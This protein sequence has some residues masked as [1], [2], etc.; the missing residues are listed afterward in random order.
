MFAVQDDIAEL[1]DLKD[2]AI[3]ATAKG[4]GG[5]YEGYLTDDALALTPMGK[6][7]KPAIVKAMTGGSRFKSLGVDD[8]DARL[9]GP[10]TGL[11][12]YRARFATP[13]GG[14]VTMLTSTVYCRRDGEWHGA[15][16]QQTP[17]R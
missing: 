2:A 17:Q 16:Y 11:V 13:E 15:F 14:E 8:V 6:L 7:D 10:D 4:D 12:T 9:L 5:F 3:Q 1:L